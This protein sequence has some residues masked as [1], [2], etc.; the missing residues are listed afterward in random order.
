MNDFTILKAKEY[1]ELNKTSIMSV[2]GKQSTNKPTQK[3]I[4]WIFRL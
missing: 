2:N 1:L 3:Q 4:L